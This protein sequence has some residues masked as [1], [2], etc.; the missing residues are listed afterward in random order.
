MAQSALNQ[1]SAQQQQRMNMINQTTPYGSLTYTRSPS[2]PGG[3]AANTTLTPQMQAILNSTEGGALANSGTY[4]QLLANQGGNIAAGPN[5]GWSETE[6]NLAKLNQNTLDPQWNTAQASLEQRLA[7]QGLMPGSQAYQT[8]MDN[9]Q[10]EKANAYNNMFLQGHNTAINDIMQQYNAPINALA[11]LRYGNQVA[12]PGVQTINTPQE[13]LTQN[14]PN[15]AALIGQNYQSQLAQNNAMMGGLFGLG[16]AGLSAIG[17][18][19]DPKDK[20]DIEP[21]GKDEDTGLDMYAYR[22]NGDPKSYPKIVGPM[23]DDIEKVAPHM[24]KKIGGHRVI[25]GFGG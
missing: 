7:N 22:Y 3:F 17:L 18:L 19:S 4:N 6:A 14:T 13:N 10:R 16:G 9:F 15:L 1:Q 5:L 8:Q 11:S 25:W 23:A 20:T 12:Q 21:L 2:S 24:V